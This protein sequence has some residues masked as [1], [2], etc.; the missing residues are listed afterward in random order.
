MSS[1]LPN[2]VHLTGSNKLS[3][4]KYGSFAKAAGIPEDDISNNIKFQEKVDFSN[5]KGIVN[6]TKELLLETENQE[7]FDFIIY[8]GKKREKMIEVKEKLMQKEL[9][10]ALVFITHTLSNDGT[11]VIKFYSSIYKLTAE[12]IFLLYMFFN[13]VQIT[14]PI[15]SNPRG[16]EKFAI[17][18]KYRQNIGNKFKDQLL[19]VLEKFNGVEDPTADFSLM[20]MNLYTKDRTFIM[21]IDAMNNTTMEKLET[22]LK[23]FQNVDEFLVKAIRNI[24]SILGRWKLIDY[25]EPMEEEPEPPQKNY[26]NSYNKNY[27]DNRYSNNSNSKFNKERPPY[28][29]SQNHQQRTSTAPRSNTANVIN[30]EIPLITFDLDEARGIKKEPTKKKKK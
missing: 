14:K 12:V 21:A 8:A 9:V 29:K 4:I 2:G 1:H 22:N 5:I 16:L 11:C 26:N 30:Q 23:N 19:T 17:C 20:E 6:H 28:Q 25:D 15:S 7:G 10:Q 18:S 27:S 13:E 24:K 3:E